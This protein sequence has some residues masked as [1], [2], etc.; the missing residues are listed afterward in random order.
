[1][2]FPLDEVYMDHV[3]VLLGMQDFVAKHMSLLTDPDKLWQPSDFLPD[4]SAQDWP[5]QLKSFRE[6][7]REIS[8]ELLVVLVGD[9]VTEEALPSYAVSLNLIACDY[10]GDSDL[11]WAK[12]LR[13]WTAEE[14][15]HGDILKIL[16]PRIA[17]RRVRRADRIAVVVL[18]VGDFAVGDC[19]PDAARGTRRFAAGSEADRHC[20]I[21]D[22]IDCAAG[23]T[24]RADKT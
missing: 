20:I 17:D 9:L 4:L 11:P 3:E 18:A 21:G 13:G 5:D 14:N 19:K 15:R 16:D 23:G 6:Q 7:A 1:M 2:D 10:E 22:H 8:D 12:W 24:G